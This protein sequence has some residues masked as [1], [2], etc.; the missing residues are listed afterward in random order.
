MESN[1]TQYKLPGWLGTIK[2]WP[3]MLIGRLVSVLVFAIARPRQFVFE[4]QLLLTGE[5]GI[6][7]KE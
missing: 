7:V 2:A 6:G 5:M 1:T 4:S 3:F